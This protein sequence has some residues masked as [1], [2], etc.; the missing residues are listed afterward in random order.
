MSE[1]FPYTSN[2]QLQNEVK[3]I[4]FTV[5]PNMTYLGIIFIKIYAKAT[6]WN[7]QSIAERNQWR[8]NRCR[9]IPCSWFKTSNVVKMSIYFKLI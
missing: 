8:K 9:H 1:V 3:I 2:E 6:H 5:A 7:L 4:S